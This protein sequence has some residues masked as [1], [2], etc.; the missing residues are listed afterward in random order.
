MRFKGGRIFVC[1][2][3]ARGSAREK[4]WKYAFSFFKRTGQAD[5]YKGYTIPK[6]V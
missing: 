6:T 2:V 5:D 4:H 3:K 1:F